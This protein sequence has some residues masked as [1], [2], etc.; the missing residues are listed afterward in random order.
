MQRSLII[1]HWIDERA[2]NL[3]EKI[4]IVLKTQL[5]STLM[6]QQAILDTILFHPPPSSLSGSSRT[7]SPVHLTSIILN[8]LSSLSF[9]VAS[10]GGVTAGPAGA[11]KGPSFPELKKVFYMAI[12]MLS[13]D[14][15]ASNTFVRNLIRDADACQGVQLL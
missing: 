13:T 11:V 4:W 2:K 14:R 5:F 12:D 6:L 10:F 15:P 7:Y 1:F 8:T 9:V 3:A